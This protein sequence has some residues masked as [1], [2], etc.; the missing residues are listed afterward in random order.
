[1]SW[2][3][4]L[5]AFSLRASSLACSSEPPEASGS[6]SSFSSPNSSGPRGALDSTWI[7]HAELRRAKES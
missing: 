2:E 6:L 4:K 3:S 5:G 1:M 7:A